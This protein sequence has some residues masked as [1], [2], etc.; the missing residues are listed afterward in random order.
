MGMK[1]V[2]RPVK[3]TP[4]LSGKDAKRFD[5]AL[6]AN[7]KKPI[8]PKECERILEVWSRFKVVSTGSRG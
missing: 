4:V 6:K 5:K 2:A 3:E 1:M 7:E 8:D